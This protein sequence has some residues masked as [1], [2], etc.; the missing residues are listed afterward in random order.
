MPGCQRGCVH[1]QGKH[2]RSRPIQ[3]GAHRERDRHRGKLIR[4]G[5]GR[6][7]GYACNVEIDIT[8]GRPSRHASM[9]AIAAEQTPGGQLSNG[10]NR[11]S[12]PWIYFRNRCGDR[13]RIFKLT[14]ANQP[15]QPDEISSTSVR[16]ENYTVSTAPTNGTA[17]RVIYVSDGD[18]GIPCL[19]VDNGTNWLR[20][21]L[22]SAVSATDSDDYLTTE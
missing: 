17:G 15:L 9:E 16:L 2:T 3:H 1:N 5:S 8:A 7:R 12:H 13:C 18:G 6:A 20:I 10:S 4:F 14:A 21:N 11:N 19:A 22:G